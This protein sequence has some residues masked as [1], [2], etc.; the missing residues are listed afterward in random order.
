VGKAPN[1]DEPVNPRITS[2]IWAFLTAL[3]VVYDSGAEEQFD[4]FLKAFLEEVSD[5]LEGEVLDQALDDLPPEVPGEMEE[6]M[7]RAKRYKVTPAS[8]EEIQDAVGVTDE[9]RKIV[10]EAMEKVGKGRKK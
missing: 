9:D 2:Q 10:K 8:A 1:R 6:F 4:R 7:D 3:K 5:Y